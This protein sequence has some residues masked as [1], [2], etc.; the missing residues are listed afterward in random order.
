MRTIH[1]LYNDLQKAQHHKLI[2][3]YQRDATTLELIF[4][5]ET[6]ATRQKLTQYIQQHYNVKV[7]LIANVILIVQS[8]TEQ[9]SR[10]S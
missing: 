9:Q 4:S 1:H 5:I 7:E 2:H 10:N 3:I 6:K 8:K